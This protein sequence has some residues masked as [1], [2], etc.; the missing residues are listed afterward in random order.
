[1]RSAYRRAKKSINSKEVPVVRE[2]V[3]TDYREAFQYNRLKGEP[4]E[5]RAKADLLSEQR[6]IEWNKMNSRVKQLQKPGP[7]D[8]TVYA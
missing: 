6:N 4:T 2:S 8:G 5:C 3:C 1:M 7:A